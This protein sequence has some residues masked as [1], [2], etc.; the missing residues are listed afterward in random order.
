MGISLVTTML[1]RRAQFHQNILVDSVSNG[2][3]AFRASVG[4]ISQA[5]KHSGSDPVQAVQQAQRIIYNSVI[6]QATML[7][8]IDCFKFLGV[9]VAL[10]V[11]AVFIMKKPKA[12]KA[13]MG[14]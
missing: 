12:G 11:P 9:A 2:N 3:P 10:M 5:L 4:G 1:A 13:I 8:Y 7:S 14:H 6:R